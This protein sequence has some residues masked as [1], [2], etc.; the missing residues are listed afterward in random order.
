MMGKASN[1]KKP[2]TPGAAEDLRARIAAEAAT[3]RAGGGLF[4]DAGDTPELRALLE[5]AR[6]A[7][8]T[9]SPTSFTHKGE[10]Y[11]LRVSIGLA[12]LTVFDTAT[13]GEPLAVG[14]SGSF[15]EHGHA[16]LH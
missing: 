15:E 3:V 7:M 9:A 2:R 14:L 5:S 16:P 12:R 13:A 1:R 10:T 4:T 6:V 8:L 11:F